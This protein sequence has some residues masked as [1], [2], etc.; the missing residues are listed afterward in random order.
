MSRGYR[1]QVTKVSAVGG[2][3]RTIRNLFRA[4]LP[5][6]NRLKNTCGWGQ[7]KPPEAPYHACISEEAGPGCS[8][9]QSSSSPSQHSKE[10]SVL[11]TVL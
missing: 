10:T 9:A 4:A 3:A 8:N 2:L 7:H 1:E 6:L 5:D 11:P